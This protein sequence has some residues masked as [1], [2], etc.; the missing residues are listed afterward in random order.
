MQA[1]ATWAIT[2]IRTL[3]AKQSALLCQAVC[4]LAINLPA[5][6]VLL[7]LCCYEGFGAEW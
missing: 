5:P 1:H 3:S 4:S 6:Q 7:Q 2:W